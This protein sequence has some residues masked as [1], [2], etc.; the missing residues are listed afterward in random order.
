MVISNG[1]Q[2]VRSRR[3]LTPAF[4]FDILRPYVPVYMEA[5]NT[6]VVSMHACLKSSGDEYARVLKEL[7]W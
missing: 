4:H 7:W 6:L 1:A 5:A 3:L 2:W